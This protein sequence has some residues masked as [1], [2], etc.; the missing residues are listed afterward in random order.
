LEDWS[1]LLQRQQLDQ[2]PWT[3]WQTLSGILWTLVPYLVFFQLVSLSSTS[4]THPTRPVPLSPQIDLIYA[5]ATV[6]YAIVGEGVFLIAPVYFARRTSAGD[7]RSTMQAL[8]FRRFNIRRVLPWIILLFLSFLLINILYDVLL[9]A[10]HLSV[11]TNDQVVLQRGRVAPISTYAA[12][13]AAVAIA[14][15]CEEVFFRS[16]IF[17]GFLRAMPTWV[18][19]VASA[20][21]FALVHQ[22]PASFAVLFCIGLALAFLRWYSNSIWP[23]IILHA[24]NNAASALLIIL[25]LYNVIKM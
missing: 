16:F 11:Q 17:M 13:I 24:L 7:M 14:P 3:I 2:T 19:I 12:L 15:I 1:A 5:L 4:S 23:G 21:L 9:T 25:T 8:G 22:D 6:V 10:L 18:A 20:F